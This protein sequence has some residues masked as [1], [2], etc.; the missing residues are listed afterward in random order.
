MYHVQGF[1]EINNYLMEEFNIASM[2]EKSLQ[3]KIVS[4]NFN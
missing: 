4:L 2:E 3:K 1:I